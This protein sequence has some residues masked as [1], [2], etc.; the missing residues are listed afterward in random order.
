MKQVN[1]LEDDDVVLGDDWCRPLQI[2]SMGGGMSDDYSFTCCYTGKPENNAKWVQVGRLY[3]MEDLWKDST[4][5]VLN[6][7]NEGYMQ[8]FVRGDIPK[9]HIAPFTLSEF[10]REIFEPKILAEIVNRGKHKGK[11]WLKIKQNHNDYY[12]WAKYNDFAPRV[13]NHYRNYLDNL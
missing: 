13:E 4:V 3:D 8:E 5:K 2:V 6:S 9:Q 7:I 1:I 12:Q 10:R 11:S